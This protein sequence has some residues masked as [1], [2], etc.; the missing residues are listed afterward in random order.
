MA[1]SIFRDAWRDT[2][3]DMR[4]GLNLALHPSESFRRFIMYLQGILPHP[5]TIEPPPPAPWKITFSTADVIAKNSSNLPYSPYLNISP[6]I[7]YLDELE[8]VWKVNEMFAPW[9]DPTTTH[10]VLH[11]EAL[12]PYHA[13][14]TCAPRLITWNSTRAYCNDNPAGVF[15][16]LFACVGFIRLIARFYFWFSPLFSIWLSSHKFGAQ[17]ES[18]FDEAATRDHDQDDKYLDEK[19]GSVS[20]NASSGTS[21]QY[22]PTEG[23]YDVTTNHDSKHAGN[24]ITTSKADEA[25]DSALNRR[26]SAFE[27]QLTTLNE[28]YDR[29]LSEMK[30]HLEGER[31]AKKAA[32][33]EAAELRGIVQA[34]KRSQDKQDK[35]VKQGLERFDTLRKQS[36]QVKLTQ[37]KSERRHHRD[38]SRFV[39]SVAT[40]NR[41]HRTMT[42]K[43]MDWV[44]REQ[45]DCVRELTEE[46]LPD[47]VIKMLRTLD[48]EQYLSLSSLVN[49]TMERM[50]KLEIDSGRSVFASTTPPASTTSTRRPTRVRNIPPPRGHDYK[51]E[52][53]DFDEEQVKLAIEL[54]LKDQR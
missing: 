49:E 47:I 54:S 11:H 34:L 25:E 31:Q 26:F 45:R 40:R 33:K 28:R 50:D 27:S 46:F 3:R 38:L 7:K 44:K 1:P 24:A 10:L 16:F 37:I 5:K 32:E 42:K 35:L 6:D 2:W 17:E 14:P 29:A 52:D 22:G 12:L 15:P 19:N 21:E 8:N 9:N 23:H 18:T 36:V 13:L 48:S 43:A 41:T 30:Q 4:Y 20:V 53:P 39:M 51:V